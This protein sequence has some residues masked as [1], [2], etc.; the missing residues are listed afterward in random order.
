MGRENK[1]TWKANYFTKLLVSEIG[2]LNGLMMRE[3]DAFASSE[4]PC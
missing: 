1:V 4:L 2:V 3:L